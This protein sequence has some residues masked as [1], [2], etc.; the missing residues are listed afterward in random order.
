MFYTDISACIANYADD[1]NLCDSHT[2]LDSLKQ[3]LSMDTSKTLQWYRNNGLDANPDKFQCVVMNR[4]GALPISIPIQDSVINSTG[5]IKVLGVLLDAK[6]NFKPYIS[7]I[8]AR[9]SRQI[10]ALR[11]L[12]KFLTTEGRLKVY[13]SFISANFSY[14]PVIWLFCGKVN[15]TKLEKLQVRAL[16]FVYND[17]VSTYDDLLCRANVFSLSIYRLRFLAIEVYKCVRNENPQYLNTMFVK[18]SSVYSLRDTDILHQPKFNTYTFGYR[19]FAYY[20]A[21]LWNS[22]PLDLKKAPN[23]HIFK[24]K[25]ND[26]CRSESA[27]SLEIF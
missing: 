14:C 11:R 22:L 19:S 18:K 24:S 3:N 12:S 2:C 7:I 6:L 21:K 15:S 23:L 25:L 1:N 5:Q 20:G 17:Y 10:N 26:W 4:N 16:R 27:K 13:K 8:C 9:A